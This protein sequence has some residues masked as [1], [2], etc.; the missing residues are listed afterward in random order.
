MRL[1]PATLTPLRR[2]ACAILFVLAT[3]VPLMATAGGDDA[4]QE[5]A[6]APNDAEVTRALDAVRA[7]P[8]FATTRTI[9]TLKWT[10]PA[11]SRSETPSWI[12]WIAGLFTWINQA[13]RVLM[14]G[15]IALLVL[16]L[17]AYIV[18]TLRVRGL[19]TRDDTFVAP[20]HVRD[21]DIRPETLPDDIGVAAR[22]LWDRGEHRAALALLYRG[23]LSRLAHVHRVPIR[24]SS[25]EGDCLVLSAT[26]L[27]PD[28]HD[29]TSALVRAWQR[30]VYGGQDVEAAAIYRL[31]DG[32]APALDA[33]VTRRASHGGAA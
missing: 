9:K 3:M 25:T 15:T 17:V 1:L 28:R 4:S 32:F 27:P 23:M 26:L 5:R 13:A 2:L 14:W 29:Y 21:L 22:R 6:Q 19:P 7:D 18:R 30:F 8:M 16:L 33:A 10:G 20:T 12:K 24:D 11:Q 31:C